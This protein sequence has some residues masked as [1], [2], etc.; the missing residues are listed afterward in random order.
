VSLQPE[1]EI[2]LVQG[3][4]ITLRW[5]V[6]YA[7]AVYLNGKGVVGHGS[8]QV[9][10][11]STTTYDLHVES[12]CGD[13]DKRLTINVSAPADT[14]GPDISDLDTTE[15]YLLDDCDCSPCEMEVSVNVVD[16]SGVAGVK[17]VYKRPGE[18]TWQNKSMTNV[19]GNTYETTLNADTWNWG[20]LEFY[21]LAYDNRGNS[22]ESSHLQIE[23]YACV[24]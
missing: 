15:P 21:V 7:T 23:V 10:P 14:Q 9:C 2:S 16:P 1:G 8:Q 13:V 11:D 5:D 17:L 3:E 22:S 4:C 24:T 19:G 20:T 18:T 12:P 6:E